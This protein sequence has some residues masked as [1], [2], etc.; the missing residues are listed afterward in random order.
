MT[1]NAL[2]WV[3]SYGGGTFIDE[4]GQVTVNNVNAVNAL[5]LA[6]SWI[7]DISPEGVRNYMEE[8]KPEASS[9]Q[10][11]QFLCATGLMHGR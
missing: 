6:A 9:R 10:E 11:M 8:R 7:G 2:E 3:A 4:K 1:T 5:T